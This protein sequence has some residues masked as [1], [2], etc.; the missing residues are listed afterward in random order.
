MAIYEDL[1]DER[2]ISVRVG[3]NLMNLTTADAIYYERG[4]LVSLKFNAEKTHLF[5]IN[6]G[7]RIRAPKK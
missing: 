7:E 3:E 6:T 5:D 2:R 4:D 1:G